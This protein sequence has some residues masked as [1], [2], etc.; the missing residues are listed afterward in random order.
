MFEK[1][2]A[3]ARE[4]VLRARGEAVELGA[5]LIGTEHLLLALLDAAAASTY[6][7]LSAAGVSRDG[8]RAALRR[9]TAGPADPLSA[10]DADALRTIGIDLDAVLARIGETFRDD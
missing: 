2:T 10:E 1:F 5:P 4:V 9:G 3:A 8:V 6:P 7:V